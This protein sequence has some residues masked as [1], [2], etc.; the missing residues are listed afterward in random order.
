MKSDIKINI[1]VHTQKLQKLNVLL[2]QKVINMTI[3]DDNV[4]M[5]FTIEDGSS[6]K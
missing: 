4:Q 5:T 1:N 3:N 2:I 6:M